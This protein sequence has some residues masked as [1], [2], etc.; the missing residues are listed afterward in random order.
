MT[1]LV[2]VLWVLMGEAVLAADGQ[3]VLQASGFGNKE[4]GPITVED[5]WEVRWEFQ[6]SLLQVSVNQT[7]GSLPNLPL[8][9]RRSRGP[10]PGCSP[11]TEEGP[12]P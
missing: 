9:R 12:T 10:G 6:G 11:K 7:G 8:T 4:L 1:R 2:L 5:R 3:V